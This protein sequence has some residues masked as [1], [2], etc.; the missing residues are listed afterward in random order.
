[1]PNKDIGCVINEFHAR[2]V[3]T[4]L[5]NHEG[6]VITG[7]QSSNDAKI[8]ERWIAPTIIDGPN[9]ESKVMTEE[10]FGPI[11]PMISF[12]HIDEAIK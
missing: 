4:M 8:E 10:V 11:L 9:L 1:M 3:A 6:Q 12:K 5:D 7:C 2:R